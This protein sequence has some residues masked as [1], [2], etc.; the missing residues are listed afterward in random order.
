MSVEIKL[1]KSK[2]HFFNAQVAGYHDSGLFSPVEA[3]TLSAPLLDQVY[4][5]QEEIV[6]LQA[7]EYDVVD[8]EALT[9]LKHTFNELH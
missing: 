3:A 4:K 9:P 5:L 2:I 7:R 1:K 8:A 6:Q